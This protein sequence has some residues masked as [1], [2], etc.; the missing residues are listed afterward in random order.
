MEHIPCSGRAQ[1]HQD[2]S[3]TPLPPLLVGEAKA[4]AAAGQHV[5]AEIIGDSYPPSSELLITS[6]LQLPVIKAEGLDK[7]SACFLG[8]QPFL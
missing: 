2:V 1:H 6:P 4:G 7:N 5:T 3:S 8:A